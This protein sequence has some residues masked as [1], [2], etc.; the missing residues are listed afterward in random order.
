[1]EIKEDQSQLTTILSGS[2]SLEEYMRK[3]RQR[4]SEGSPL[5]HNLAEIASFASHLLEESSGNFDE[6]RK[7]ALSQFMKSSVVELIG[8]RNDKR[9]PREI[10]ERFR[11]IVFCYKLGVEL[12]CQLY[13]IKDKT[14]RAKFFRLF[15]DTNVLGKEGQAQLGNSRDYSRM[16]TCIDQKGRD[17]E[18]GIMGELLAYC[19]FNKFGSRPSL[20][21][22][23]DDLKGIDL[24]ATIKGNV[25]KVQVKTDSYS[26]DQPFSLSSRD[27]QH[28]M[29]AINTTQVCA[30]SNLL[31]EILSI[32]QTTEP[33]V[34]ISELKESTLVLLK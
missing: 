13:G 24:F 21:E 25:V 19:L 32:E 34:I 29:L 18:Q 10:F 17:I 9:T 30:D 3:L 15:V 11:E 2:G 26:P 4:E 5:L 7:I 12:P 23:K 33:S 14:I 27:R 8:L 1:M 28:L 20:S 6:I 22:P 16:I 31:R